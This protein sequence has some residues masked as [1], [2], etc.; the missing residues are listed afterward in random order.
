MLVPPVAAKTAAF[1]AEKFCS[2][3]IL[4]FYKNSAKVR[5]FFGSFDVLRKKE[6]RYFK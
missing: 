2:L 4:F 1:K 5:W 6:V 3:L